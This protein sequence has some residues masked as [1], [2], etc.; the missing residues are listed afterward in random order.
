MQL[1]LLFFLGLRVIPAN[2]Q[3]MK[4]NCTSASI[5]NPALVRTIFRYYQH[6]KLHLLFPQQE[7]ILL[8]KGT[9]YINTFLILSKK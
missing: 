3:G 9:F 2:W 6:P 1:F 7:A 5:Q 4:S 8:I